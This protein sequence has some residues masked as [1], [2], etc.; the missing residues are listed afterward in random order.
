MG[1]AIKS[2]TRQI[3]GQA[4]KLIKIGVERM[5]ELNFNKR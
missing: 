2:L 4:E 3:G 1:K 5:K